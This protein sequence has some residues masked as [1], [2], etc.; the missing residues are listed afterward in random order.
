MQHVTAHMTHAADAAAQFLGFIEVVRR[1]GPRERS[2]LQAGSA[3]GTDTLATL[4][5]AFRWPAAADDD[6]D[7]GV[8]VCCCWLQPESVHDA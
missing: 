5:E 2:F 1:E 7:D 8:A 3:Q 4:Q 6:D